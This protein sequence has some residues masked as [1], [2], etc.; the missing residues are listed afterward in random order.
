MTFKRGARLDPGQVRDVRGRSGGM[1]GR[2]MAIGGGG[3]L[4][5]IIALVLITVLGGGNGGGA[6]GGLDS[7]LNQPI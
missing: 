7:I 4:I 3:G 1:G 2:G 6:A 5:G